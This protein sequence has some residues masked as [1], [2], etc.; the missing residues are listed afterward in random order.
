MKEYDLIVSLGA[1][2]A[3]TMALRDV[4]LQQG[5]WPLDWAASPG[6]VRAVETIENDFE[7][8][9]DCEDLELWDV[10]LQEGGVQRVYRN[11]RTGFGFPHEFTNASPIEKSYAVEREKYLRR[12]DRFYRCVSSQKKVLAVYLEVATRLRQPD[13]TLKDV[14][15]RLERKFPGVDF[16]LVYIFERPDASVP[17]VVSEADGVTCVAAHYGKFLDGAPMHTVSRGGI[18]RFF[19]ENFTLRGHDIAAEKRERDRKEKLQRQRQWGEGRIERWVNRKLFK[20]FMRMKEYLV[21]Q[22]LIPGDRPCW[23]EESDR[24]W[25]HGATGAGDAV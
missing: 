22:K 9:F 5:S 11:R 4:G 6:L 14:R 1:S 10:R 16:D 24:T 15:G 2:C 25:P 19:H 17:V 20:T 8:W 21:G 23:F 3:C 18:M 7:H 12:I 13:G